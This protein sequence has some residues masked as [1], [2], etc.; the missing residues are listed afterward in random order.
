MKPITNLEKS[1]DIELFIE[2]IAFGGRG[3]AHLNEQVVFVK[4]AIP[5]QTVLSRIL[6]KHSSFLEARKL[7]VIKESKHFII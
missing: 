6:K 2:S 4:D 1:T 7:E 3:V 5:G